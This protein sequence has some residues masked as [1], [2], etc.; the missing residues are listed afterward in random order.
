VRATAIARGL[1]AE[2]AAE[3]LRDRQAIK[4]IFKSATR[5]C[6]NEP[7][8]APHGTGMSVVRALRRS[9][10]RQDRARDSTRPRNR[11]KI[12]MPAVAA[13]DSQVA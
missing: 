7:G 12:T 11:F 10:R 13:E 4:L 2:D 8:A 3:R 5:R 9:G 1:I 6:P